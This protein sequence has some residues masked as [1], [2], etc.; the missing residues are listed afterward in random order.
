MLSADMSIKSKQLSLYVFLPVYNRGRLT[1]NFLSHLKPLIPPCYQ[2]R[3]V[4]LDDHCTDNTIDLARLVCPC[5]EIV[6]LSGSDYWGGALNAIK[7]YI[8][9]LSLADHQN[10]IYMVCNDDIRFCPGSLI[11]ALSAVTPDVVIAAKTI[12]VKDDFNS[13][14]SV[15]DFKY[16]TLEVQIMYLFDPLVGSFRPTNDPSRVNIC[17]T[18][19][20]LTRADPWLS[21][22]FIP[23]AIPH[24]LS[25]Y[26][27]SYNFTLN[28]FRIKYPI[29]FI[30][31]NSLVS[32]RNTGQYSSS[33]LEKVSFLGRILNKIKS[34]IFGC[35]SSVNK[36]S[37]SYAPAW[38]CF[39][40]CYSKQ[41]HLRLILIKYWFRFYFGH[42]LAF[43]VPAMSS[44]GIT[45]D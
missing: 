14:M 17:E 9:S 12:F 22:A 43:F 45:Y 7:K 40:K 31:Y 24:Y 13:I 19:A 18:R 36:S 20:M 16:S 33:F 6:N 30:C 10:N 21:C 26:W 27:L 23:P 44:Q 32:T 25:D 28:G 41:K 15:H 38:A 2:L 42:V 8:N 4:L 11:S 5:L 39:L 34:F 35:A 1:A 3:P 29:D 37:P